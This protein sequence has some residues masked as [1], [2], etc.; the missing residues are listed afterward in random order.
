MKRLIL[1]G[2]IGLAVLPA[3]AFVACGDGEEEGPAAGGTVQVTLDEWT[4]KPD[5][6]TVTTG[7]IRF[8]AENQG[9]VPHE[10]EVFA[11]GKDLDIAKLPIKENKAVVVASEI[12][13]I[14]E[15]D[16]PKGGKA[17]ITFTFTA[18]RYLLICNIAGHYQQGMY[19]DITAQ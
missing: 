8:R 4:I 12:G 18:G 2:L 11:I 14:E 1:V 17:E 13:E 5:V 15:E 19:A 10:L 6:K 9:D 3:L 16:L 7:S